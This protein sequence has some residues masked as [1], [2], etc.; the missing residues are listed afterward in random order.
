MA[1]R[2]AGLEHSEPSTPTTTWLMIFPFWRRVLVGE[3]CQP[4]VGAASGVGLTVTAARPPFQ[5]A[6]DPK[7]LFWDPTAATL[8][9]LH[10]GRFSRSGS[11]LRVRQYRERVRPARRR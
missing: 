6:L 7:Y 1:K 2:S 11:Q 5:H 10:Q 4:A 8:R 9:G 3:A